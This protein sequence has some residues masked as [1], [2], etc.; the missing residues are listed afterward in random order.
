MSRARV[1]DIVTLAS[2]LSGISASAIVG[3]GRTRKVVRIRQACYY[4]ARSNGHSYPQIGVR[5]N[6][7]HSSV[8][9]G[10]DQ[11]MALAARDPEYATFLFD[12]ANKAAN[13][14]PFI[15]VAPKVTEI[16]RDMPE[17]AKPVRPSPYSIPVPTKPMLKPQRS[18]KPKNDF[19]PGEDQADDSH[20]FDSRIATGT[21]ALLAA[22]QGAMAA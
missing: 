6:R 4:V 22:L 8:L 9:W 21:N 2:G 15:P 5:M 10:V 3:P 19:R 20:R 17:P 14:E 11:A 12:L 13:S 18:L 1:L 16:I 7:D